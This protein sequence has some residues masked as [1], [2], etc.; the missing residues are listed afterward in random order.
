MCGVGKRGSRIDKLWRSSCYLLCPCHVSYGSEVEGIRA[1]GKRKKI[2]VNVHLVGFRKCI[3]VSMN[4]SQ[5]S[6]TNKS[7]VLTVILLSD[8]RL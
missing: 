6:K 7:R 8:S 4:N 2:S 1:E 5:A 3:L